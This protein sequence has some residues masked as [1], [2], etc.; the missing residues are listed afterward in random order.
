MSWNP[1]LN[2]FVEI[3]NE[4]RNKIG[5]PT[6][7]YKSG[8]TNESQTCLERWVEELNEKHPSEQ[9]KQYEDLISC[10]EMN[11]W[12]NLLL[13]RYARYS[14]VY[15][16]EIDTSGEDFWDRYGGFYRECRSVVIDVINDSIVLAPFKK[17]FNI[18]ELEETSLDNIERRISTAKCVEFSN[19]LDGS[20]QSAT[21]Y[22]GKIIMAG[23]QAIDPNNSWRLQDGYR[24][25]NSRPGYK[26]MLQANPR[27]TFIFEYISLKDAH[28]VKYSKDQEGLYLIGV[29]NNRNGKEFSY[30]L[31]LGTASFYD[32]PTTEIF[33]KTL[34][35][36]M[37][38]LDDKSSD[39]AEGFV[40][41]IDGY[42]VKVKYNDYVH[43]HK[44]LSKLSSINLIIKSIADDTFDDLLSKLP[45]AYHDNVKRVANIVIN[46]IQETE[47]TVREYFNAAPKDDRK[48]FMIWVDANIPRKYRGFCK[49]LYLGKPIN[50]IKKH[51]NSGYLKLKDMG[52]EDYNK[53]FTEEE[54]V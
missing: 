10:L 15:D 45:V 14:N 21:W 30:D 36:V 32:I 29:R 26:E 42:K 46:Y 8:Y 37:A 40:V 49:S 51:D 3:K 38:E 1:V 13:I 24:M 50:V 31:V 43:I 20:M 2:K 12:D 11:Q 9:C 39:E 52:V 27:Y 18:N 35:H 54:D 7:S 28:V 17:F 22:D 34:N 6:Y 53:V 23:S 5:E 16:G 33:E 19:K 25:I 44:A 4:Y 41:N 48:E 47:H